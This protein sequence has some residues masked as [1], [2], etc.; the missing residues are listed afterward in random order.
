MAP[1]ALRQTIVCVALAICAA[2]QQ[3]QSERLRQALQPEAVLL[4]ANATAAGCSD[5]SAC[6]EHGICAVE[7]GACFCDLGYSGKTCAVKATPGTARG[8][9]DAGFWQN[10][11]LSS[12]RGPASAASGMMGLLG[13][14]SAA[15]TNWFNPFANVAQFNPFAQA[16][17]AAKQAS[18]SVIN[19]FAAP[20]QGAMSLMA[21]PSMH[22]PS[23][24]ASGGLP[25]SPWGWARR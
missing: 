4:V 20:L 14:Q 18:R 23:P 21:A 11:S 24:M 19:P 25:A 9:T 10:L 13:G 8:S 3:Q 22:L 1:S 7:E 15:A 5:D 12:V 2:Q 6:G 17:A 16:A